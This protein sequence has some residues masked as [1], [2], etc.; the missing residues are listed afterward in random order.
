MPVQFGA[1]LGATQL[2]AN[3]PGLYRHAYE[4]PMMK[5]QIEKTLAEEAGISVD[6][7]DLNS[8]ISIGNSEHPGDGLL[9]SVK[10]PE[11]K[12]DAFIVPLEDGTA[13]VFTGVERDE[14]RKLY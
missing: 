4:S 7:V 6:K 14:F 13:R 5:E 8:C 10:N 11:L 3:R 1:I 9:V 12:L 2:V